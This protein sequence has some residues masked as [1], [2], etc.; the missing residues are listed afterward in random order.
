MSNRRV[1]FV[2]VSLL[3][4]SL[5]GGKCKGPKPPKAEAADAV[6]QAYWEHEVANLEDGQQM[7]VEVEVEL[8]D[9]QQGEELGLVVFERDGDAVVA[10]FSLDDHVY[11]FTLTAEGEAVTR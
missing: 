1:G 7:L 8:V 9:A 4:L 11:D 5:L 2:A 3:G 10:T 6:E